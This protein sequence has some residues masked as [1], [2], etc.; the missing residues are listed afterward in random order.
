MSDVCHSCSTEDVLLVAT[1]IN[2][3][4]LQP[5]NEKQNNGREL[6][7]GVGSLGFARF[8]A[9]RSSVTSPRLLNFLE[10]RFPI[11]RSEAKAF[12]AKIV[13]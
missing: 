12:P 1:R 7:T 4:G 10:T 11:V 13:F 9:N 3:G 6:R 2:L 5:V 8:A